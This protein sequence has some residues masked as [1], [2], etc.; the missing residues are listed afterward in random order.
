MPTILPLVSLATLLRSRPRTQVVG[1]I[2][3]PCP[4][5][6]FLRLP[7]SEARV[8]ILRHF[9]TEENLDGVGINHLATFTVGFSGAHLKTLCDQATLY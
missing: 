2:G 4:L 7:K 3:V 8:R 6:P 9:L 1:R 5:L